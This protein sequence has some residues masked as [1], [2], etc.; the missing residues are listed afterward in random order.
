M[1]LI[2]KKYLKIILKGTIVLFLFLHIGLFAKAQKYNLKIIAQKSNLPEKILQK[3]NRKTFSDSVTVYTYLQKF[4]FNLFSNGFITA[5]FDSIIFDSLSI[6]AY[7]FLGK[8]Y[9]IN[10][11]VINGI[12][13]SLKRKYHLSDS[14]KQLKNSVKPINLSEFYNHIIEEYENSGFPFAMLVPEKVDIND[15]LINLNLQLQKNM[16]L[17][18]NKIVVKGKAKISPGFLYR[19]LSVFKGNVYNEGL[20]NS[21]SSKIEN[22]NFIS[23][24]RSTEVDFFGDKADIYLYL[25]PE[26][27]NI[28]NGVIGFIPDKN[29]NNKFFFTGNAD[30]N[31]VN[32]FGKGEDL[33]LKWTR[34]AK[35]SQKLDAGFTLPYILKSPF[36]LKFQ[37]NL[38]KRDTSFM[39]I[40][41]K[42]GVDFNFKNN[43]GITAFAQKKQSFSLSKQ[44]TDT[45]K[46]RNTD[47][48]LLGLSYKSE[49]YDY[50]YNP[51]R[52]FFIETGFAGGKRKIS[53]ERHIYYEANFSTEYYISPYKKFVL[54]LS[55]DIKYAFP[56]VRLYEN[57]L[58][59]LGG[60]N[61]LRGFYENRFKTSTYSV[62]SIE[63]RYLYEKNSNVF[64]FFN[65]AGFKDN[66]LKKT[67]SFPYG[68]GVG[69]NLNTKAG[70]F[71]VVYALG[72]LPGSYLQFSN[73]K[74]HI[75][76]VNRF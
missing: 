53:N 64:I 41:S 48:L 75:G 69:T 2:K 74:I 30:L 70:V 59:D 62:F 50:K 23:E 45:S 76:Y 63:Q 6:Q 11:F 72:T 40:S 14:G 27:A 35:L 55:E 56:N 42:S 61:S 25:K 13:P 20:I 49:K 52:G 34:T 10:D 3:Y 33:F 73:S 29:N 66:I 22:L 18:F 21:I 31:L 57:E 47:V 51:S 58:F 60:F 71:S 8:K 15:S 4:K 36:S 7:L 16:H 54:K 12:Y 5:S 68:F 39:K 9:Q 43:E 19:Y 24:I 32:N 67:Y 28:F 17:K 37:F 65:L 1:K 26:R 46:Y 44:L 38:D